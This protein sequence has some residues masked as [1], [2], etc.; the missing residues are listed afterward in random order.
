MT[1]ELQNRGFEVNRKRVLRSGLVLLSLFTNNLLNAIKEEEKIS[2]QIL[3]EKC[4]DKAKVETKWT[5][6]KYLLSQSPDI[7]AI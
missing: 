6:S 1:A 3:L 4:F 5:A 7:R 2:S